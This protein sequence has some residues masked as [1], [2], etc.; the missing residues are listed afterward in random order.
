MQNFGGQNGCIMGFV[1]VDNKLCSFLSTDNGS[2]SAK[3]FRDPA[4]GNIQR[5]TVQ[6][7]EYRYQ[8]LHRKNML[9]P[10]AVNL[11]HSD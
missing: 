1:Q 4:I 3:S 9:P 2:L 11:S 8:G 10:Q 5:K 6:S 7:F